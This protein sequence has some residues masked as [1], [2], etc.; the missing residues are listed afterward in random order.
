M[1]YFNIG[2]MTEEFRN[3]SKGSE[4]DFRKYELWDL[5][6]KLAIAQQLS[7]I[8]GHLGKI[9]ENAENRK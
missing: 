7:V 3:V 1:D 8:S 6:F 2:K 4:D 5:R 9:V